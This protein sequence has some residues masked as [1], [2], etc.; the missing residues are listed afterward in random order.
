VYVGVRFDRERVLPVLLLVDDSGALGVPLVVSLII[1]DG[2]LRDTVELSCWLPVVLSVI[3]VESDTVDDF[4]FCVKDGEPDGELEWLA[5][6][7]ETVSVGVGPVP[8]CV[9][10]SRVVKVSVNESEEL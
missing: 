6:A 4:G 1:C 3:D 10:V 5:T 7:C 8:L 9:A 2:D